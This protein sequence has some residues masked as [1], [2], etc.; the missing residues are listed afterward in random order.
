MT[1]IFDEAN[2]DQAPASASEGEKAHWV[3]GWNAYRHALVNM[4]ELSTHADSL[5]EVAWVSVE[6][7][8]APFVDDTTG[9]ADAAGFNAG[10]QVQENPNN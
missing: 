1:H 3:A 9:Q 10:I 8:E 5:D 4:E 6:P 2:T 7:D